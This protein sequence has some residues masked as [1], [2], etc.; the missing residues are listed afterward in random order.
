MIKLFT[1][2]DLDGVGCAILAYLA[3]GTD[4]VDV[5]YCNYDDIDKKVRAFGE[6]EEYKTCEK[7]Y[8][9][10]ISVSEKLAEDMNIACNKGKVVLLDHHATALNLNKY[11]WCSVITDLNGIKTSGTELFYHHLIVNSDIGLNDD[12]TIRRFVKLVRDYDTWRWT[13]L[14][15]DGIIC[16]QVNDLLYLYGR[17][18]FINWCI[19][20]IHVCVFPKLYESDKS[21]LKVKQKEIDDY[22]EKKNKQLIVSELCG[23]KCGFVFA[24]QYISELG[25]RLCDMRPE[26]DFV[27]MIDMNGTVSYRSVKDNIDLGKDVAKLFGGGGHQKAAGSTFT[28]S[29]QFDTIN[30]IFNIKLQFYK[31]GDR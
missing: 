6:S 12:N 4:N 25:N 24:E 23:R 21:V 1:H 10:D 22:V 14:G 18:K 9:T 8:I 30:K 28:N 13:S 17:N 26:I 2:T 5:E 27:A 16:K 20:E 15:E 11:N 7:V 31:K 3:F 19:S 29:V